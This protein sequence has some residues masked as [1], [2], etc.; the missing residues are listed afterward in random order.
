MEEEKN[1]PRPPFKEGGN[2]LNLPEGRI[3]NSASFCKSLNI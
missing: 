2:P 1:K 3:G